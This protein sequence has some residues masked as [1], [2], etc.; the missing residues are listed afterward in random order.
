MLQV[1]DSIFQV[2]S[3]QRHPKYWGYFWFL[4][5]KEKVDLEK[6]HTR[7]CLR[8]QRSC[9]IMRDQKVLESSA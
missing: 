7:Q 4:H 5:L 8:G 3:T 6:V 2:Q 1:H 9:F